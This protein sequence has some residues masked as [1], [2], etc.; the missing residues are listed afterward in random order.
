MIALINRIK[1]GDEKT[2]DDLIYRFKN[3]A[4]LVDNMPGFKGI[5]LLVNRERLE[6]IVI[7]KWED[8]KYIE[9]WLESESF[10]G[11]HKREGRE[12]V[13]AVSEGSLYEVIDL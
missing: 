10:K 13:N 1:A 4:R 7:T 5:E 12:P 9:D 6:L 3:R 8:W 2:F 11:V